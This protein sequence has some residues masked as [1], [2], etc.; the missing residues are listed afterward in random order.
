MAGESACPPSGGGGF[1]G[2]CCRYE[3]AIGEAFPPDDFAVPDGKEVGD[4]SIDF[5][6]RAAHGGLVRAKRDD[7]IALRDEVVG[8]DC[9]T[10]VE[11]AIAWKNSRICV[12]PERDP[13]YGTVTG[14]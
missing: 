9:A 3:G 12:L 14:P 2:V 13:A 11:S 6:A 1:A 7:G 8:D 5:G 4:R 10:V